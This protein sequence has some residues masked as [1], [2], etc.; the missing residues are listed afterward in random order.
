MYVRVCVCIGSECTCILF[1]WAG[2]HAHGLACFID[3]QRALMV[4]C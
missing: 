2:L 3:L 1:G 4:L